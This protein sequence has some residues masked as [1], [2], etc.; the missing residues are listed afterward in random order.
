MSD[1]FKNMISIRHCFCIF[2]QNYMAWALSLG[3]FSSILGGGKN[4]R[5]TPGSVM[6][7]LNKSKMDFMVETP[8]LQKEAS[9]HGVL[10]CLARSAIWGFLCLAGL[11]GIEVDRWSAKELKAIF[12]SFLYLKR[13]KKYKWAW[14]KEL[15]KDF[16]NKTKLKKW[17]KVHI[18]KKSL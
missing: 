14:E 4:P 3:T 6:H 12:I 16:K 10:C 11:W 2:H 8:I 15:L 18:K 7:I 5:L 13:E 9:N 17:F 1:L